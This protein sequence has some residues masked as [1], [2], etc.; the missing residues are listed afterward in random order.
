MEKNEIER[1]KSYLHDGVINVKFTKSDGE[2]RDMRCTQNGDLIQK[3]KLPTNSDTSFD[4]TDLI[5]VFDV[6]IDEWRSFK[7]SRVIEWSQKV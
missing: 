7:P 2:I 6:D 4:L 5:R 3:D 1:M